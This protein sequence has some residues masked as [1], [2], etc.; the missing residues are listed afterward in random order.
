MTQVPPIRRL[1]QRLA[2]WNA[3]H[4]NQQIDPRA[5]FAV[6]KQEGLG[7]GIGDNGTSFGPNQLHY[8]GAYPTSAPRGAQQSQQ[9]AWSPQGI[10]Y[11]LGQIGKVAGGLHGRQAINAIVSRFERPANPGREIAGANAAYGQ[12][13]PPLPGSVTGPPPQQTALVNAAAGQQPTQSPQQLLTTQRQQL[14]ALAGSAAQ[15]GQGQAPDLTGFYGAVQHALALQQQPQPQAPGQAAAGV[16]PMPAAAAP[17]RAKGFKVGDPVIGGTSIGGA[18]PTLGL[19]GYPARDYFAKA[20]SAV[21]APVS[22]KVIR[23]SGHDPA[24]GPVQGPHG[25]LGWSVYIQG[26]D[27]RT[28]FLTHLGS[29]NVKAGQTVKAG[30][31][32]GTVADYAK[33]GTPSHV[34]MGVHG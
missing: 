18:H 33:Y 24:A 13:L 31:G 19:A 15:G 12:P 34:H 30:Q 3:T 32:I 16:R 17:I 26:N 29:R 27:G 5:E 4:P 1:R 21:V 25:P 2:V 28:Y 11:A 10:D 7:G 14:L 22:G 9:W 8:G 20:G 23:L 6:A